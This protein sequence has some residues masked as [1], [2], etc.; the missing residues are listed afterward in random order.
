MQVAHSLTSGTAAAW[1][2]LESQLSH[3]V[4]TRHP[5]PLILPYA[6]SPQPGS[7]VENAPPTTLFRN[8]F[9]PTKPPGRGHAK[10]MMA[11]ERSQ[12]ELAGLPSELIEAIAL[13]ID[14]YSGLAALSLASRR[15]H[16]C[17]NPVLYKRAAGSARQRALFWAA[18]HGSV[19]TLE[20]MLDA[21]A[22]PDHFWVSA[23][24]Q[25][26]LDELGPANR[27]PR[28]GQIPEQPVDWHR[29]RICSWGQLE[30]VD[31]LEFEGEAANDES[32]DSASGCPGSRCRSCTWRVVPK[33]R[34]TSGVST[35][36]EDNYAAYELYRP[37]KLCRH[38]D[39]IWSDFVGLNS[40]AGL[41]GRGRDSDDTDSFRP[42]SRRFRCSALHLAARGGHDCAVRILISRGAWTDSVSHHF[43]PCVDRRG[44]FVRLEGDPDEVLNNGRTPLHVALC[45][46]HVST[47]RLLIE[48]GAYPTH[49]SRDN[50]SLSGMT[51]MHAAA[52]LGDLELMQLILDRLKSSRSG[53]VNWEYIDSQTDDYGL[54][55]LAYAYLYRRWDA[56]HWLISRGADINHVATG[57]GVLSTSLD[58]TTTGASLLSDAIFTSRMADA[59]RLLDLGAD[60]KQVELEAQLFSTVHYVCKR[61][62]SD[63]YERG[64]FRNMPGRVEQRDDEELRVRLLRRLAP[65]T[66]QLNARSDGMTPLTVAVKSGFMAVA[67]ALLDMGAELETPHQRQAVD[68]IPPSLQNS[69][70]AGQL[71][72]GGAWISSLYFAC[73]LPNPSLDMIRLLLL[74]GAKPRATG[75]A[76]HRT[77]YDRTPLEAICDQPWD[78]PDK[79]AIV[80]LLLS[81]GAA[82]HTAMD[83]GTNA[84]R[85][86]VIKA[87]EL[88]FDRFDIDVCRVLVDEAL[89]PLDGSNTAATTASDPVE[90]RDQKL[91]GSEIVDL[92]H[93]LMY[94]PT[95]EY[96]LDL[97]TNQ[98]NTPRAQPRGECF[99]A[100]LKFL[101]VDLN[102]GCHVSRDQPGVTQAMRRLGDVSPHS[103]SLLLERVLRGTEDESGGN[104]VR[105]LY[106]GRDSWLRD[107][108]PW[109]RRGKTT[110]DS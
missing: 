73:A 108:R 32:W 79:G 40:L 38:D 3:V 13:Q 65:T 17:A 59:L 57:G 24:S 52:A 35:C 4:L 107:R 25:A 94:L 31:G 93:V 71:E 53:S 104:V 2:A 43:C 34:P 61:F 23:Y 89:S 56:V 91:M 70:D 75:T 102:G 82:A 109:Y 105:K 97:P 33:P 49:T 100:C 90:T 10:K 72:G 78:C 11:A 85:E 83:D 50:G 27:Q 8:H 14:T 66:D 41:D 1:R 106:R 84:A 9:S 98:R 7:K 46:G 47:A 18:A 45:Y 37:C 26:R 67:E 62:D 110:I 77:C 44:L 101:L 48:Q 54:A 6:P 96:A 39:D 88:S 16:G 22:D 92:F 5:S 29:F 74:R 86:S 20:H 55:P 51:A 63:R 19:P 58:V 76:Y 80:R 28:R 15:M 69:P 95:S 87:L 42:P 99:D 36:H 30:D 103:A 64:F 12:N 21:G 81:H 68:T 60:P